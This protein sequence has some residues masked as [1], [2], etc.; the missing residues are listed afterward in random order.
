MECDICQ[1]PAGAK[2]HLNCTS[3]ARNSLYFP[4]IQHAQL[5]LETESIGREVEKNVEDASK[6]KGLPKKHA[7]ISDVHPTFAIERATA[8]R[9]VSSEKTEKIMAQAEM[10]RAQIEDMKQYLV[11][12]RAEHS[13]RRKE[14]A[15]ARERLTE[16]QKTDFV[17][18]QK[19]ITR[20]RSHWDTLHAKI[21]EAR[22][23]LCKETAHLY[24]LQQ[25]KRRKGTPG[26]D[27]YFIG[28]L[29]VPDLRD[30]NRECKAYQGL[31]LLIGL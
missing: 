31:H 4:R 9:I 15:A 24:G 19:N 16:R 17:P 11:T 2:L 23:C 1:R 26:R 29:P 20:S 18:V 22:A 30:L 6:S 13:Q 27:L 25:R 14:L 12:K 8:E 3:C 10:L 7:S 28:G 21:A 5:L